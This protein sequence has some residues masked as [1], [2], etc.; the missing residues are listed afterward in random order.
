M[1]PYLRRLIY[2]LS[3]GIF[4]KKET[5]SAQDVRQ[6]MQPIIDLLKDIEIKANPVKSLN[7]LLPT[8]TKIIK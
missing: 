8:L 2:A 3:M 7:K 6:T 4:G 5:Y 1:I